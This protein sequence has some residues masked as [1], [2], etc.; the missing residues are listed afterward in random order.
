MSLRKYTPSLITLTTVLSS[1]L[2]CN[3]LNAK[4]I[5]F[6]GIAGVNYA[7]FDI[8]T[9]QFGG[10]EISLSTYKAG[11]LA[12]HG[13]W[14]IKWTVENAISTENVQFNEV[15]GNNEFDFSSSDVSIAYKV[16]D[17]ISIYS[18]YLNTNFEFNNETLFQNFGGSGTYHQNYDELG[19][20]LGMNYRMTF[21]S[22]ALSFSIAYAYL[23]ATFEDNMY[24]AQ[25]PSLKI[26]GNTK[27]LS[28]GVSWQGNISKKMKYSLGISSRRYE[29]DSN[30]K[31]GIPEFP[32]LGVIDDTSFDSDWNIDSISANIIYIF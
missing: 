23:D 26:D 13:N 21:K 11:L 31:S 9:K 12:Q 6:A 4:E 16:N 14:T 2:L 27:G 22:G 24:K 17:E 8:S 3:S 19:L 32:G 30:Y 20:Y 25:L 1:S 5:V 18:G 15:M 7:N 10:D 28:Y 29:F